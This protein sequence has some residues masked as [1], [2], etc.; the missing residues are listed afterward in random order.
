V[1]VSIE[2]NT[3]EAAGQF[4]RYLKTGQDAHSPGGIF[5]R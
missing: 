3:A 2:F 1:I 5:L 4:E